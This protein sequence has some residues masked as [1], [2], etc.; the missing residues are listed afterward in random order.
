MSYLENEPPDLT[1][2]RAEATDSRFGRDAVKRVELL[3]FVINQ[4]TGQRDRE[5]PWVPGGK[6]HGTAGAMARR[7]LHALRL[8][9]RAVGTVAKVD[10]G[11]RTMCGGRVLRVGVV[12]EA[13]PAFLRRRG[14]GGA[15]AAIR[16]VLRLQD[17]RG[18]VWDV[19][20]KIVA[21]HEAPAVPA[22]KGVR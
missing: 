5:R 20:T 7:C 4:A 17:C 14:G 16:H 6:L 10:Y 22:M 21:V 12:L 11:E 18:E 3:R 2:L 1:T 13:T 19:R 9:R 8:A 15:A